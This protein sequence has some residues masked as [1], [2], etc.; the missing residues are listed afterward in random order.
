MVPICL[1]SIIMYKNSKNCNILLEI[2]Q[3]I[4]ES[5]T[6]NLIDREQEPLLDETLNKAMVVYKEKLA[7]R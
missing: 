7:N 3:I 5:L 4:K 6:R 2:F 1:Y